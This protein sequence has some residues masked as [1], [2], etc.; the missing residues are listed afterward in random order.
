MPPKGRRDPT[1][2]TPLPGVT[3]PKKSAQT[4][5]RTLRLLYKSKNIGLLDD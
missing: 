5:L 4:G 3:H 1:L 2:A